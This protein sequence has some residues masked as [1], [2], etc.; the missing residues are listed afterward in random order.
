MQDTN[1]CLKS[2]CSR[3]KTTLLT[4]EN[5]KDEC[6]QQNNHGTWYD[7]QVAVL[8]RYCGQPEI[9]RRQIEEHSISRL[10]K[11]IDS[12][13]SQPH[14]LT[15]T[16]SKTYCVFNLTGFAVIARVAAGQGIDLWS[17]Q[18]ASGGSLQLAVNW[19]LPY[20]PEEKLWGG[21]QIS[22]YDP[23]FSVPLLHLAHC[24]TGDPEIRETCEHLAQRPW[25]KMDFLA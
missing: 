1:Q 21:Q 20:L 12:D 24:G 3:R 6:Q 25:D 4:S 23:V 10:K 18:N 8:A 17:G 9:A 11:Q 19:M 2:P 13:G 7:A 5:G 15:R 16:L 14:E 22:L